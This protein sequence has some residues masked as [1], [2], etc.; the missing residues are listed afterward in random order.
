ML[1]DYSGTLK[2]ESIVVFFIRQLTYYSNY[3]IAVS[4]SG[5]RT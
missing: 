5:R 3:S 1:M 2:N 4:V